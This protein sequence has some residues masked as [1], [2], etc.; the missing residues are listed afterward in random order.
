MSP[1]SLARPLALF[2]ALGCASCSTTITRESIRDSG[3][4]AEEVEQAVA[5]FED[6]VDL[7][8]EFLASDACRTL[9][10]GRYY[11]GADGSLLFLDGKEVWPIVVQNSF[12][13]NIVT[14]SGFRAQ[15]RDDGFAVGSRPPKDH[16]AIDNSM[17]REVRGDWQ[18]VDSVA[19]LILHET[20]H[21]W[22]GHGTV[23][24][25]NTVLYYGEVIFTWRTNDHS[26]ERRPHG[27]DH[28]FYFWRERARA[29]AKGDVEML[30]G[31]DRFLEEHYATRQK[32]CR[33]GLKG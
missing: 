13:G 2:V 25:W 31:V 30:E 18:S 33:H 6:A 28:E 8:N 7:A 1:P 4:P 15:E 11:W 22:W 3:A 21:T 23:G 16:P 20:T 17:F 19:R 32:N 5:L 27:I 24:Y 9:P 14:W 12:T 29:A 26:A 10:H